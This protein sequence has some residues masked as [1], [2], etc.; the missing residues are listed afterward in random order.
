MSQ[1]RSK[2]PADVRTATER[3]LNRAARR[4]LEERLDKRRRPGLDE[5]RIRRL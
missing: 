4:M 2:L 5:L 1:R 3:I